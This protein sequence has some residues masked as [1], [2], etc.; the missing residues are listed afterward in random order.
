MYKLMPQLDTVCI[1]PRELEI[2]LKARNFGGRWAVGCLNVRAP[3][4]AKKLPAPECFESESD[5]SI[6]RKIVF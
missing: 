3:Y 4:A 5:S 1:Y 2:F 6:K